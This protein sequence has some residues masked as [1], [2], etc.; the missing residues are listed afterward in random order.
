MLT[1]EKNRC[2]QAR[3]LVRPLIE[4]HIAWLEQALEQLNRDSGVT[5][6]KRL[7]WGARVRPALYM[8]SLSAVRYNPVLRAFWI[9]LR[10]RGKPPKVA[11]VACMHKLLTIRECSAQA[12]A[13]VA[14]DPCCLTFNTVACILNSNRRAFESWV[15]QADA[16]EV[17]P[18]RQKAQVAAPQPGSRRS[19][20]SSGLN[21]FAL[22]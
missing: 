3:G 11:L 10:E 12:A 17:E 2:H 16:P 7:I 5:C 18:D 13:A 20:I 9:R 21:I 22:F 19:G 6:G 14:T 1:A 15:R 4:E 8:S